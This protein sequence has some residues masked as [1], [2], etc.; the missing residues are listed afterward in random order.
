MTEEK[1][2]FH[3]VGHDARVYLTGAGQT[4][5]GKVLDL[6]LK[7]C[8]LELDQPHL[9]DPGLIYQLS[10]HLTDEI[11]IDMDV[12]L[13]HQDDR[14]V[15]LHSVSIDSDS[16]GQLHRLIELNLGDSTLLERDIQAM[17]VGT[18]T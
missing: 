7:G 15:G 9:I 3:R 4:W 12:R 11:H 16:A 6:S 2:H 10:I 18:Q 5:L 14:H 17:L 8:L 13:A 1:R